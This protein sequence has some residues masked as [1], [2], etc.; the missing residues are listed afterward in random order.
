MG[1]LLFQC[2]DEFDID[3]CAIETPVVQETQIR[4]VPYVYDYH[5]Q[6][7]DNDQITDLRKF[8]PRS[9]YYISSD[10]HD[11]HTFMYGIPLSDGRNGLK[12]L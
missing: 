10:E 8:L 12:S 1:S 5:H 9:L 11:C 3:A 6:L 2:A 7:V 4:T